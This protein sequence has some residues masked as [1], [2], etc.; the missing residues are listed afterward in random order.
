[1]MEW[2]EATT[3]RDTENLHFPADIPHWF[4]ADSRAAIR[5]RSRGNAWTI[6]TSEERGRRLLNQH[7]ALV[8]MVGLSPAMNMR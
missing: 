6:L 7:R 1:M 8:D 3:V 2:E 5:G 4:S